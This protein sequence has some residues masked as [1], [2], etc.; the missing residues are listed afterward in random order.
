MRVQRALLS[1]TDKTGL[2]DFARR[3]HAR[4]VALVSTGGTARALEDGKVPVQRVEQVTA[5]P[6]VLGGRVKSLHPAI[7]AAILARDTPQDLEELGR[8]GLQPID[9][10]CVNLY[11]FEEAVARG[12]PDPEILE[13]IDVGGPSLIRAA[14]KNHPRVAVVTSPTQYDSVAAEI[15]ATGAVSDATRLLLAAHAFAYVARYD[16]IIDQ[17]FR[18]HQLETDFPQLL[19]LSFEKLQDLRYGENAH[20]RAAFYRSKPTKEPSVVNARQLHGKELSF[21]NIL[22]ADV[23]I[24]LL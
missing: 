20:Q 23:A 24:E 21:N 2:V 18:H 3:L 16:T 9:L 1:V 4:G 10:V 11:R 13:N 6:E 22:D 19:N 17:Y 15:E 12:A 8:H 5:F 7:F 14:A